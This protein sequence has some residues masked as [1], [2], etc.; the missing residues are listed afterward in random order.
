MT[1]SRRAVALS[2]DGT[3]LVYA[4]VGGL[5]LRSMSEFEARAIPGTDAAIN[6]AFS[7]DG[8]SLVFWAAVRQIKR[9]AVSGGVAVTIFQSGSRRQV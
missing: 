5:Y 7:P 1:V 6:P 3:R 2:P 9:I 8:Q 4:A